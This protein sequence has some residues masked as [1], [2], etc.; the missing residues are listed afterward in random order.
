MPISS[1]HFSCIKMAWFIWSYLLFM[2]VLVLKN[3]ERL[4]VLSLRYWQKPRD[5]N[6]EPFKILLRVYISTYLTHM[7]YVFL[8]QEIHSI[9]YL[10]TPGSQFVNVVIA[11]IWILSQKFIN[12]AKST[13]LKKQIHRI[14]V[15]AD[16]L[17]IHNVIMLRHPD[18]KVIDTN[19]ILQI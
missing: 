3:F 16:S 8:C 18:Y 11:G 12:W 2:M 9:C 5:R 7:N 10:K 14:V 4:I 13:K 17:N 1:T 19:Y 15:F 6:I